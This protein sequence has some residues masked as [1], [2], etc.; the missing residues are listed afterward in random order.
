MVQ[1]FKRTAVPH[2]AEQ[3]WQDDDDEHDETT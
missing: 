1:I 3:N 2:F